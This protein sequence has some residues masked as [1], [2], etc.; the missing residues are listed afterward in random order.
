MDNAKESFDIVIGDSTAKG[1]VTKFSSGDLAGLL[2][3]DWK[4]VDAWFEEDEKIWVHP[5][6]P[7]KVY[8][9][10]T[11]YIFR[12]LYFSVWPFY[13]RRATSVSS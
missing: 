6:D 13:N 5:K 7:Y 11:L 12:S 2:K 1:A 4:S 9:C 3:V 10:S 8:S